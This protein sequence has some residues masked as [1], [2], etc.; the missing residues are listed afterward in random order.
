MLIEHISENKK[1]KRALAQ[2][3]ALKT[4]RLAE[5]SCQEGRGKGEQEWLNEKVNQHLAH[6]EIFEDDANSGLPS[7]GQVMK[8]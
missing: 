2:E 3:R 4:E 5:P 1:Q 7:H 8:A 6:L